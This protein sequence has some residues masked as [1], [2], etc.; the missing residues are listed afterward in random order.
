[1][2][3]E[4]DSKLPKHT[5][6]SFPARSVAHNLLSVLEQGTQV[7]LVLGGT[8]VLIR[9]GPTLRIAFFSGTTLS[10]FGEERYLQKIG[11]GY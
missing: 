3:R 7:A 10:E 9:S 11:R 8:L 5:V 4:T 6:R 2:Q 1:V